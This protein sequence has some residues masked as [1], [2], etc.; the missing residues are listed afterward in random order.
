MIHEFERLIR[1]ADLAHTSGMPHEKLNLLQQAHQKYLEFYYTTDWE[2][3]L[4]FMQQQFEMNLLLRID[5]L[6]NS[7]N[8]IVIDETHGD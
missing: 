5:K 1:L 3:R 7:I 2:S 4:K 8:S 6:A